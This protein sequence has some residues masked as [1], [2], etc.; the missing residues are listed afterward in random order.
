MVGVASKKTAASRTRLEE[1][2]IRGLGVIDQALVEFTPGLNVITGETGAG[3]TMVL[4]ALALLLGEKADSDLIRTGHERLSVSG[5]FSL[6]ESSQPSLIEFIDQLGIEVSEKQ[7]IFSRN[8]TK[9]GKSR[10]LISGMSSTATN[11][12]SLGS[13]LIEVH[14]QHGSLVLTKPAKQRELLDFS[15]GEALEKAVTIYQKDLTTYMDL[16]KVIHELKK[17]FSR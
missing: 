2:N 6:A 16:K 13:E 10:A 17:I 14:G 1:I 5:I 12:A 3:K 11:L 9:D 8:V 15:G 7:I 4:T